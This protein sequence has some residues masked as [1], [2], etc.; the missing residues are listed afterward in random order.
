MSLK[1]YLDDLRNPPDN[2]WT[3]CRNVRE[4]QRFVERHQEDGITDFSLDHDLGLCYC[5]PCAFSSG[6]ESCLNDNGEPICGCTCHVPEPSGYDFLKWIHEN[7]YWPK[8]KPK[9]HSANPVAQQTMKG[10]IG[11]YGPYEE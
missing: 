9:V 6:E 2:S 5:I 3:V 11:R 4:A 8:N 10:F 7:G 1:L